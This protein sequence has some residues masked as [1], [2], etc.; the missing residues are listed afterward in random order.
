MPLELSGGSHDGK[1]R[2]SQGV[3]DAC[4]IQVQLREDPK[5]GRQA[6]GGDRPQQPADVEACRAEHCMQRVTT[7][8]AEPAAIPAVVAL[9][10]TDGR[11]DRLAPLEPFALLRIQ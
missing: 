7:A 2:D 6:V 1:G 9:G 11:L 5:K 4:G 10:V 3:A 8:A